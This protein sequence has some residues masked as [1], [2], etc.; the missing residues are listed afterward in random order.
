MLTV[1]STPDQGTTFSVFFPALASAAPVVVPTRTRNSAV[2]SGAGTVMI[3][4]DEEPVRSFA[5]R[6]LERAGYRVL[7]AADGAKA[8]GLYQAHPGEIGAVVLDLTMPGMD[9]RQV[10]EQLRAIDPR[11]RII[12]S[13][14]FSEH[15]LAVRGEAAGDLFLQKPYMLGEL[16]DSVRAVM[17]R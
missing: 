13:S 5:R 1:D 16:L 11:V 14:G 9:G 17:G 7:D 8:M 12:L 6:A 10:L 15:D 3:V 2:R 4:D